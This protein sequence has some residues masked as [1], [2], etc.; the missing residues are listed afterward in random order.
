[1]GTGLPTFLA[2]VAGGFILEAHG[3]TAL[4]LSYAV[5]PVVGILV[6]L[7]RGKKILQA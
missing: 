1:V 2:S 4:F 6:L 7:I 5:V 3:F